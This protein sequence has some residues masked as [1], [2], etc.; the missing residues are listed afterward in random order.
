MLSNGDGIRSKG[1]GREKSRKRK[2]GGGLE[3]VGAVCGI[4]PCM[5]GQKIQIQSV[6]QDVH[7]D[8]VHPRG[9]GRL[10]IS[11]YKPTYQWLQHLQI[12]ANAGC[13]GSCVD[14]LLKTSSATVHLISSCSGFF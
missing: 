8:R 12:C 14:C 1:Q 2:A 7:L 11:L 13:C 9:C 4:R 5:K 3:E 10:P 6:G